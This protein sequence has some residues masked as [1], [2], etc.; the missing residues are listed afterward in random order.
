MGVRRPGAMTRYIAIHWKD[1]HFSSK[2]SLREL[3]LAEPLTVGFHAVNRGRVTKD[4]IV[5]VIGCGIV[6]LWV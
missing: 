1:L 5:A 6:G 3:A 4:D 2:L